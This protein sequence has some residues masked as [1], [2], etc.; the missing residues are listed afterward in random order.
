MFDEWPAYTG[1]QCAVPN[2]RGYL[3]YEGDEIVQCELK[4]PRGKVLTFAE[5]QRLVAACLACLHAGATSE[6]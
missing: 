1:V 4:V 2:C 3:K 5:E 6:I